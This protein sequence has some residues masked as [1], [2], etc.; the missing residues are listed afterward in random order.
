MNF[1]YDFSRF[2]SIEKVIEMNAIAISFSFFLLHI[3]FSCST[4]SIA[5]TI[6]KKSAENWYTKWEFN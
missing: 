6:E 3:S 2:Q 5:I 1:N 4:L